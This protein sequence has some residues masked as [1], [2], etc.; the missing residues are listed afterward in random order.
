MGNKLFLVLNS[1]V[2]FKCSSA[3]KDITPGISSLLHGYT[4]FHPSFLRVVSNRIYDGIDIVFSFFVVSTEAVSKLWVENN[5]RGQKLLTFLCE[6]WRDSS[7]RSKNPPLRLKSHKK[8]CILV[9][10]LDRTGYRRLSSQAA[11]SYT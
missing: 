4:N 7:L 11:F 1:I 8:V 10:R 2:D 3:G 5:F 6:N 9:V